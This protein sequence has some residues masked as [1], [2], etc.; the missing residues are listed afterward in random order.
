MNKVKILAVGIGGYAYGYLSQLLKVENPDFEI[1]GMVDVAPERSLC[2]ADLVE[3]GVPLYPSMEAFYAVDSADLAIITTPI[4]FH[5]PQILCALNHGSN[6]MCEKPLSGVSADEEIIIKAMEQT[7]KFVI[8]GYQWSYTNAILDLKAD[9]S[10][11]LYGA[12]EMLKSRVF[13]PRPKEYYQRGS[14]WGGKIHAPNGAIINDS[15]VSNATSHYLHNMLYVTGGANDKSSEVKELDCTLLRVNHIEN[16]D[17]ATVK[18]TL[19]NGAKGLFVVSHSTKENIDPV[20]EYRFEKGIVTYDGPGQGIVGRLDD[21]SCKV[22][23]DP[24][25]ESGA[26]KVFDAIAGCRDPEYVPVCGPRAAAEQVRCVE[27]IQT[28]PI[29]PVRKEQIKEQE[30]NDAHYLYVEALDELLNRCYEQEIL[31]KDCPELE[32][33]VE[34]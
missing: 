27:K 28:H 20:F 3:R 10:A 9:I 18:F 2:Y 8:I 25:M 29:L 12:P 26:K 32:G 33:L 16:F 1:A 5:T 31:L 13:W 23:G 17:T 7:G 14:G 21:G 24:N 30:K 22:Y 15:V 11:G 4:H 6:V 19:A 34:V